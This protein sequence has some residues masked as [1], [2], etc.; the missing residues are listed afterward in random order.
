MCTS[1]IPQMLKVYFLKTVLTDEIKGHGT[2]S[3]LF[4][5]TLKHTFKTL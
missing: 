3:Q 2:L 5:N 1:S 4:H